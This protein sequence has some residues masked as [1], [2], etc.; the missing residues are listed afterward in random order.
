MAS[1]LTS[2]DYDSYGNPIGEAISHKRCYISTS[3]KYYHEVYGQHGFKTEL[4]HILPKK[5]GLPDDDFIHLFYNLINVLNQTAALVKLY[6]NIGKF[7]LS[8]QIINKTFNI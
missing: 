1:F 8:N 2:Y 4:M 5:N 3:Y 7:L 6:F